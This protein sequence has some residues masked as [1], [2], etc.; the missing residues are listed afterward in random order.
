[1]ADYLYFADAL[2]VQGEQSGYVLGT[3][4]N[5]V[6]VNIDNPN[7]EVLFSDFQ[8]SGKDIIRYKTTNPNHLV[9]AHTMSEFIGT[10]YIDALARVAHGISNFNLTQI[11]M[12]FRCQWKSGDDWISGSAKQWVDAGK[13]MPVRFTRGVLILGREGDMD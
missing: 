8:G 2:V 3:G 5:Q 7:L 12:L 6:S 10:G 13:L 4:E 1:M 9:M 11:S